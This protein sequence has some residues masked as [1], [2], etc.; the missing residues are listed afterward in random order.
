ML[1]RFLLATALVAAFSLHTASAE[2]APRTFK[3]M[4]WNVENFTDPFDDPYIDA[5]NENIGASKRE[6]VLRDMALAIHLTNPDVIAFQEIESDRATKFFLDQYLPGHEY[7]FFAGAAS[8]DWSQ[9]NVVASKFPL[10][11]ITSFREI[12]MYNE[13]L[14]ISENKYNPRL[15]S[16]ELRPSPDDRILLV[17]LHL[18]AGRDDKDSVWRG[19]QIDIIHEHLETMTRSRP[20]LGIIVLG[21]M[22]FE[23][24]MPEYAKLLESGPVRLVDPFAGT[25]TVTHSTRT[26]NRQIDFIFFNEIM[27]RRYVP[28][29]ASVALPISL[30]RMGQ[31]SDHLPVVA[32]FTL[33]PQ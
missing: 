4:C 9:N 6:S 17:N 20:E 31:I 2:D 21:D 23:A 15:M 24:R 12:E 14:G 10:G 32:T 1:R 22:N 27:E 5:D 30:D 28:D 16:V 18:K 25:G 26:P 33:E 11:P 29:S 19:H 13:L 3:V 7:R 8:M